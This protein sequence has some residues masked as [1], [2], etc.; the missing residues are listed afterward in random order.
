MI[1]DIDAFIDGLENGSSQLN[2]VRL[3]DPDF[4]AKMKELVPSFFPVKRRG[5]PS[6]YEGLP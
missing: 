5:R 2:L 6:P 3:D 1:A 4:Q